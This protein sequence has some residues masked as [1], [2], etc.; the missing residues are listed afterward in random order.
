MGQEHDKLA[1][2]LSRSLG[3]LMSEPFAFLKS[4][5]SKAWFRGQTPAKQREMKDQLQ[6][7]L[8]QLEEVQLDKVEQEIKR[9]GSTKKLS[10]YRERGE[11]ILEEQ[12]EVGNAVTQKSTQ[13]VYASK[14]TM[15]TQHV[16]SEKS[17]KNVVIQKSATP[18]S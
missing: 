11:S 10:M 14:T 17:V 5:K 4:G 2:S 1:K 9:N 16:V 3:N 18:K 6:L 13:A 12:N 7:C 15:S 8:Q